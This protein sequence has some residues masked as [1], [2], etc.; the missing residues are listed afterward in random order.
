MTAGERGSTSTQSE[1]AH[2]AAFLLRCMKQLCACGKL[3]DAQAG[4]DFSAAAEQRLPAP[5]FS[6]MD[7]E[8]KKPTSDMLGAL[9][10]VLGCCALVVLVI[11]FFVLSAPRKAPR[12]NTTPGMT[13][14]EQVLL[15]D[16]PPARRAP[17]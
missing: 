10:W 2:V 9:T 5:R 16:H 6:F 14:G 12:L 13:T 7:R 15:R 8:R 17:I 3:Q 4:S 11:A 1:A